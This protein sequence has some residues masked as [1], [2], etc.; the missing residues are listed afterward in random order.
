MK[1]LYCDRCPREIDEIDM[2]ELKVHSIVSRKPTIK[3]TELC[4]FCKE[5]L[6][7]WLGGNHGN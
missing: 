7:K 3:T 6:V 5:E 1:K 2:H 4:A